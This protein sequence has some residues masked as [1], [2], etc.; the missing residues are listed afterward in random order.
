MVV[1]RGAAGRRRDD[2]G[3]AQPQDAFL[4]VRRA[5]L[6]RGPMARL[7][8][9]DTAGHSAERPAFGSLVQPRLGAVLQESLDV[10]ERRPE[11]LA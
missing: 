1:H 5:C 11:L 10:R 4:A 8:L 2:L 6:D 3:L 7:V 9:R